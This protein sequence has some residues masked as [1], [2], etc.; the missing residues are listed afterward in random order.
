MQKAGK[1]VI[2]MGMGK[3]E[4]GAFEAA[5]KA[6]LNPLLE[7]S[8]IEGARGILINITGGPNISLDEIQAAAS[9]IHDNAHEE[10]N[11]ILGA[12]IDPE[13]EEK[14]RVTVIATG[15]DEKTEKVELPETQTW[16]PK[17]EVPVPAVK[18]SGKIFSKSID[19]FSESLTQTSRRPER[20]KEEIPT[21]AFTALPP[22]IRDKNII[23]PIPEQISE[24]TA[25]TLYESVSEPI[26][27]TLHEPVHEPM[28][29]PV[30]ETVLFSEEVEVSVVE[31]KPSLLAAFTRERALAESSIPPEDEY[32]IPT[33]LRKKMHS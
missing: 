1:A 15:L 22:D 32:D 6:I 23:E 29:E 25:E 21:A 4:G 9:L 27:E 28:P 7:K 17:K 5:K 14:I 12:V 10:A 30:A 2:G 24:S 26:A 16:T 19:M 8:S 3:G 20:K 33:F 31:E 11:I 13:M 18:S